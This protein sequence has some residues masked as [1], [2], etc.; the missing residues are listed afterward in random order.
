MLSSKQQQSN[1]PLAEVNSINQ[2]IDLWLHGKSAQ[3]QR[4]YRRDVGYFLTFI[5]HK[6]L[7][8]TTLN[9]VQAF[10]DALAQQGYS[11]ST[12]NRRLSAIK[13]LLN[14][15]CRLGYL[16]A[17]AGALVDAPPVKNTLAERILTQA[18]VREI[19][20]LEP[21]TRNK[22]LLKFLYFSGARVSEVAALRWR[23]LKRVGERGQ[24]TLQGKGGKTRAIPLPAAL[25]QEL[26]HLRGESGRDEPVFRSRKFGGALQP[27]QIRVIVARAGIRAG[28]EGVSP[29]WFRHSHA[30]HSLQRGASIALVQ[31]S[32]GHSDI[33]TT[34]R[35]LHVNPD[36]GS[37]LYLPG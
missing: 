30:S 29:H 25:W 33:S 31:Q 13:S 9:D 11:T 28:I 14:F 6:D 20:D 19:V 24:A 35:Y 36:D 34:A 23:D 3:S 7:R 1:H 26:M 32:L 15:G 21:D 8:Q 10:A 18:E 16:T 2:L 37:G 12:Q 4:A 5:E 17:N 22:L 27:N